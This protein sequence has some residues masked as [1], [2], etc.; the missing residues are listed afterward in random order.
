MMKAAY[1]PNKKCSPESLARRLA[2]PFF[3][4]AAS[5]YHEVF[6]VAQQ[7]KADFTRA[8]VKAARPDEG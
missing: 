2:L 7:A 1:Y 3:L 6:A 5:S 8:K 4:P